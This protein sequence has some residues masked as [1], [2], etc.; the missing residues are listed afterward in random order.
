M[1]KIFDRCDENGDH[2][3]ILQNISCLNLHLSKTGF[4]PSLIFEVGVAFWW[5]LLVTKHPNL[6]LK[7]KNNIEKFYGCGLRWKSVK[8]LFKFFLNLNFIVCQKNTWSLIYKTLY[9][10]V[11][12]YCHKLVC[13]SLLDNFYH[14]SLTFLD[15]S[16]SLFSELSY[17]RGSTTVG[18]KLVLKKKGRKKRKPAKNKKVFYKTMLFTTE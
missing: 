9:S 17:T 12:I 2:R 7:R 16:G 10:I 4:G 6:L 11:I 8:I 5:G 3:Q 18:S 14:S 15:K 1:F 13:L